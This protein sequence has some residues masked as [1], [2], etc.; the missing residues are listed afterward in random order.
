[1]FGWFK[2]KEKEEE[3][4]EEVPKAPTTIGSLARDPAYL[5]DRAV[6]RGQR[7]VAKLE[8]E[9]AKGT[10]EEHLK[11]FRKELKICEAKAELARIQLGE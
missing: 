4:V 7:I 3:V 9:V 2:S 5:F 10:P 11:E 1:M 6:Q 8:K